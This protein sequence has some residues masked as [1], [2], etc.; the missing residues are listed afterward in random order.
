MVVLPRLTVK[1]RFSFRTDRVDGTKLATETAWALRAAGIPVWHDRADLLPGETDRRLAEA[2]DSGLS[3][4][5]LLV[6]PEIEMSQV[7]RKIE[8]PRLLAL[9]DDEAF[10]FSVLSAVEREPGKLDY[11]APDRLL[12]QRAGTL[13][14][15]THAPVGT[16]A[17]RS[18][19]AHAQLRRRMEA[20]RP[21][22]EAAGRVLTMDV[23][24]RIPPSAARADADLVINDNKECLSC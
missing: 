8:L 4:A 24:T 9:A 21:A 14:R 15:V 1:V 10:T 18:E 19:A 22:A 5:V 2:L 20:V 3:G 13:S 16:Q 23:Q 7:I 17:Q 12:R 11:S 6:T